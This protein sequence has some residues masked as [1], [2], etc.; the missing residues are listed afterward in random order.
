MLD[1]F[2]L[3]QLE[4]YYGEPDEAPISLR[5]KKLY[6]KSKRNPKFIILESSVRGPGEGVSE[7]SGADTGVL[8]DSSDK[9]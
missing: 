8:Q 5:F 1:D 3:I 7:K 6:V 4:E 2:D 9:L